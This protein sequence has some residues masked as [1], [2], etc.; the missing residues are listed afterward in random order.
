MRSS[1]ALA[2][3]FFLLLLLFAAAPQ[4]WRLGGRASCARPAAPAAPMKPR[5]GGPM[6]GRLL[7]LVA[8]NANVCVCAAAAESARGD[9]S[10]G[11]SP[12]VLGAPAAAATP[13]FDA[14]R[15]VLLD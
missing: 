12:R 10:R 11:A 9:G 2:I 4:T 14:R 3:L 13:L 15:I 5:D 1:V 6:S 8:L 7:P